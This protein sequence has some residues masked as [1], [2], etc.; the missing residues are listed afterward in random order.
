MNP[1]V[2]LAIFL[3]LVATFTLE[4]IAPA[5]KNR[6]D[7]RWLILASGV[8]ALQVV[9]ALAA[10]HFFHQWFSGHALFQ[11]EGV[12]SPFQG[13]VLTFAFAS[14]IGYWWHRISH[15]SPTLW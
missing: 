12:V 4:V 15:F 2:Y 13:G 9:V 14:F 7:R 6:C 3:I 8:K 10:G 1:L 5:S 11:L